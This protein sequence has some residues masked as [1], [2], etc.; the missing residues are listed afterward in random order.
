MSIFTLNDLKQIHE[1]GS[2]AE[3][4]ERQFQFFKTGFSFS[5]LDRAATV[6]D[7]ILKQERSIIAPMIESYSQRMG[8]EKMLKFVPASGA[9]SRMFK[10]L[11][12]LLEEKNDE[13][14]HKFIQEIK[15]YPFY[16]DLVIVLEKN[17]LDITNL[18]E[19]ND[20][21]TIIEHILFEKGLNYSHK[22]KALLK[23]FTYANETRYAIEEHLVEGARYALSKNGTCYLHFTVSPQH[24]TDFQQVIHNTKEKYENRFGIKYEISYSIQD[25]ATDTLAANP[26]NEPFR[27]ENGQ[28]LFRPGGH[29]ALLSNLNKMDADIIFI[30]NI[31][32]I[33]HEREVEETVIYKKY[34]AILLQDLRDHIFHFLKEL[35]TDNAESSESSFREFLKNKFRITPPA[36][37]TKEEWINYLN[38][39]I[40]ICGMVRNEGEP[41]G[42]PFWVNTGEKKESLQIVESSQIDKSDPKQRAILEQATHFNPVDM[43]CSIKN[44][45][46]ETFNLSDFVDENSGFISEKSY[47][48]KVLKA[49]ELP[50]LWNGAMAGWLT[51]FV[52]VPLTTFNPVKTVHD[53]KDRI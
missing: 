34:L 53:M 43:V 18:I 49:M 8:R 25:P 22:P 4:V 45:R 35:H 13:K 32:N 44:W 20:Y 40:R 7:G 10:S 31:D 2:I 52:E 1:R 33:T 30:K 24:L 16:Q 38:R 11:F 47:N 14:G 36:H 46:G 39:P 41:G 28:L 17:N 48:G 26:D 15:S 12:D 19:K 51:I 50:G 3:D 5:Q 21:L 37:A 6:E 29:G 27:E 9:A 23:F 42:G